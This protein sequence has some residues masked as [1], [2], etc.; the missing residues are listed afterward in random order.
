MTGDRVY[1]L[2]PVC[3]DAH[4]IPR[5]APLDQIIRC[6]WCGHQHTALEYV[7]IGRAE[8]ERMGFETDKLDAE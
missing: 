1:G 4:A 2:C 8:R 6:G 7:Q 3:R 5:A